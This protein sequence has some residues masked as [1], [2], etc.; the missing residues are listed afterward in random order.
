MLEKSSQAD[1]KLNQIRD[2]RCP[3]ESFCEEVTI[4]PVIL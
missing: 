3:L 1:A 2:I 4:L